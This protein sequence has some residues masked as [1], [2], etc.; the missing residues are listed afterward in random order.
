[1]PKMKIEI[2][3]PQIIALRNEVEKQVGKISGHDK[4]VKLEALIEEKCKE[5]ISKT[6]LERI[7][8]YSTRNARF[9]SE[10][11][12]DIMSSFIGAGSWHHFCN[13]LKNANNKESELFESNNMVKCCNLEKGAQIRLAWL[14]DR[15]CD[16]EYLG[17]NRFVAVKSEN[18]TIKAGDTFRCLLIEKGRELYMDNFTRCGEAE[19]CGTR[20]VVGKNNGLTLVQVIEKEETKAT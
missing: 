4:F 20:Y 15:V 13:E 9:V 8:G 10:R 18:A 17:D 3:S 16:V 19:S 5:H 12:L 2:K 1:M 11:I 6:T 14:P 7:W